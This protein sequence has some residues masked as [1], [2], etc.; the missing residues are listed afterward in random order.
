MPEPEARGHVGSDVFVRITISSATTKIIHLGYVP[1][2][3]SEI[4][5]QR[6]R[7]EQRDLLILPGKGAP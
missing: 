5:Y 3:S 4:G 1:K 6:Q 2:P 7:R